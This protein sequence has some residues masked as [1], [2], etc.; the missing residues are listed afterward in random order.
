MMHIMDELTD[1]K[2]WERKVLDDEIVARWREEAMAYPDDI[3]WKLA[4]IPAAHNNER[5]KIKGI[6]TEEMFDYVSIIL[7]RCG[8]ENDN[9]K[10]LSC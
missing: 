10:P 4:A 5:I 1:K 7:Q 6:M 2:D 3:L 8:N 9:K